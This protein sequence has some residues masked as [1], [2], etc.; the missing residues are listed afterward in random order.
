[1]K[2]FKTYISEHSSNIQQQYQDQDVHP[3]Q[4]VAVEA[5]NSYVGSIGELEYVNPRLGV[6]K[7]QDNLN[8]F[9]YSFE[10]PKVEAEGEYSLPLTYNGGTFEANR[11]ENPYGEFKQGDGIS[12]HIPGGI[13]LVISVMP[14]GGGKTSVGAEIVKNMG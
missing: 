1:M 14:I 9:G 2:T 8:K 10:M 4:E 3:S 5:L 6:S 12:E 13:N 7:L 11:D